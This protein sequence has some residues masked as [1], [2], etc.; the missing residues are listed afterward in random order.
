MRLIDIQVTTR[1]RI[2]NTIKN[3]MPS[4]TVIFFSPSSLFV[5]IVAASIMEGGGEV[6]GFF[7]R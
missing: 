6:T 2:I 1:I 5:S 7:D 3:K 4:L